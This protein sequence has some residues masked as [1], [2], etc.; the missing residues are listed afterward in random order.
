MKNNGITYPEGFV[1]SGLHSGIKESK[2][3]DISL[4]F[5]NAPCVAA[6]TFTTNQFKSFSLLWS[7]KNIDN[8][9]KA[10]LVNSGNANTCNGQESRKK[11]SLLAEELAK[12]L[13]L[14]K[15]E[16]LLAST[17]TI[18]KV[19]PYSTVLGALPE[20]ISNLDKGNHLEAAKG[21][22]T[23]DLVVK[24]SHIDTGIQGRK[25]EVVLGGMAKGSGMINPSMAT[26]L[27]FIT[28]DAVI[29]KRALQRALNEAVE[30]S[31][32]MITV[33]NDTSTN[34]MVVCLANGLSRNPTI[35]QDSKDYER[36]KESLKSICRELALKIVTD[37]EGAT[38]LIEVKVKGAWR[39][40]D[41]R[42]ISKKIAGSNLFKSAVYGSLPNWGRILSSVGSVHARVDILKTEVSICGILVYNGNPVK[43]DEKD[44]AKR[45]EGDKIEVCVDVKKGEFEATGWGCDLTEEY[46]RI[47]KE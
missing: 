34:D 6:G 33:D 35:H 45:M 19:F 11:T 21:I 43:Y 30:D 28:T 44:L 3:N 39:R 42:R 1:A 25:K 14:K 15:E 29:D 37:G 38:K 7:L 4:I 9:I 5:S 12:L 18:G 26:M 24:E 46:V 31:F 13:N 27:A 17:G 23:T 10:V 36:F 20:L 8:L 32:N 40:D 16:V 47:N 41:A 2:K 22:L